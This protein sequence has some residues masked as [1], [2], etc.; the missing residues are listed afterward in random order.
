MSTIKNGGLLLGL[1]YFRN[2]RTQY[3]YYAL[4]ELLLG[5]RYFRNGND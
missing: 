1:R 3:G 5:L 2:F 4:S